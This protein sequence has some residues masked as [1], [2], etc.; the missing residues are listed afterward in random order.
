M[1]LMNGV[2]QLPRY[3]KN[4]VESSNKSQNI[5]N[6]LKTAT[7]NRNPYQQYQQNTVNT[8]TPQELTLMLYNGLVRFLKLAHQGIEEKNIEK[9]NNNIIRSQDIITEFICTLDMQYEVSD[10]LYALYEYMNRRLA[11]ANIK[12]D[13]AIIEEVI[14]YSEELRDTWVQAMKL[15]KQQAVK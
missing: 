8:A 12:K 13:M 15:T 9:S 4:V 3:A 14:G 2:Y 10:G 7:A 1:A 5:D 11:E 6:R